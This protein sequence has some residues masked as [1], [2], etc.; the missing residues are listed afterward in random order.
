VRAIILAAGLSSRLRPHTQNIPK[1]LLSLGNSTCLDRT[2]SILR[3]VGISEI[4]MVIG[5]CADI[6][7]EHLS[8]DGIT[9]IENTEYASTNSVYSLWSARAFVEKDS[10]GFVVVN[11][12]LVFKAGMLRA[13]LES[14][15]A[16]GM[17]V[18]KDTLDFASDMVK[19]ELSGNRI[20]QMSKTL[21][22]T[23]A[24]AEAVGPVKLSPGGGKRFFGQVGAAIEN[25]KR[26]EWFFYSLSDFAKK[27]PFY[28]VQNP[29]FPWVEIDTGEDLDIALERIASG[30]L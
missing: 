15:V 23:R 4:A 28:A 18:D 10:D 6:M 27:H 16:D 19:I 20:L 24:S 9:F 3:E 17:I 13:L 29:G 8:G 7:R 12:D 26:N 21:D 22:G 14:P 5:Y 11:S 2:V 30:T 1:G 25:G